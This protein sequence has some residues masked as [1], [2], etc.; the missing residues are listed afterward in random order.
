MFSPSTLPTDTTV[1]GVVS[2]VTVMVATSLFTVPNGFVAT[3]RNCAPL[4]ACVREGSVYVDPVNG[5]AAPGIS[6]NVP[7]PGPRCHW[8]VLGAAPVTVTERV[9]EEPSTTVALAGCDV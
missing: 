2:A 6:V 7:S 3:T 5:V 4:S 9:M 8:R 1:G